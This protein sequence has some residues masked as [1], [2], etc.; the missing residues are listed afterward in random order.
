[1]TASPPLPL[2]PARNAA[3]ALRGFLLLEAAL[4]LFLW[5]TALVLAIAV[6]MWAGDWPDRPL[7]GA[8]LRLAGQW[9][10]VLTR[11]VILDNVIY[12]ALLLVLRALLPTPREG[13]YDRTSMYSLNRQI[14]LSALVSALVKARREAPFPAFLV[15]HLS[16]LPPLCW[17][18]SR[19]F[20]PHSRSVLVLD[21]LLPDPHL[22]FIGRNVVVGNM[23]SIIAH[24]HYPD[25]IEV[26]RTVIDDDAMIGAHALIYGGCTIGR[27]AV[28]YGGAVVPPNTEIGPYEA[29][30]GV[31]ALKIRDLAGLADPPAEFKPRP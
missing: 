24:N 28:V 16:N 14:V 21:P 2:P 18:F 8:D 27:G 15:F 26:R 5:N 3:P 12:L 13:V 22:T 10:G 9:G 20:G 29:W 25:R 1:M 17:L 23:T 30:G 31:P 6:Q 19:V 4:R 7:A 11:F